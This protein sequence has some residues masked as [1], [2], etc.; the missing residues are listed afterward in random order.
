MPKASATWALAGRSTDSSFS[1]VGS[2]PC[3]SRFWLKRASGV[4]RVVDGAHQHQ[5]THAL[6]ALNPAA[7]NQLVDSPA[8]GVAVNVEACRQL[9]LGGQIVAAAIVMAQ[10]LLKSG[11]DFLIARGVTGRMSGQVHGHQASHSIDEELPRVVG[12]S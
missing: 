9:L 1:L 7:L 3:S 6:T 10:L 2:L 11:G 4:K 5:H 8:Q 12:R